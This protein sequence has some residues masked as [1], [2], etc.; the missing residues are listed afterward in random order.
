MHASVVL[1]SSRV[2]PRIFC[3]GRGKFEQCGGKEKIFGLSRAVQGHAPSENFEII[4][5]RIG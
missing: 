4:V 5:F 3:L 2:L 1:T